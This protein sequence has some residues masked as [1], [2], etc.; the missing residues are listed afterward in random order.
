M[1]LNTE[2]SRTLLKN[3]KIEQL[4]KIRLTLILTVKEIRNNR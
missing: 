2:L 1:K 4:F 3:K